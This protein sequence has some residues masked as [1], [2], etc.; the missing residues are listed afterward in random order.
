MA[1]SKY[2][3]PRLSRAEIITTLAQLQIANMVEQDFSNPNPDLISELYTHLLIHLDFLEEENEQLDFEAVSHFD[4]PELHMESIRAI[5]L[6]NRIK[7]VMAILECPRKF[8]LADLLTPDPQRTELFM[9]SILNFVLYRE[10]KLVDISN[11]G[12]EVSNLE[13]QR[14]KLEENEI[15]QVK[16]EISN[17]NE[18]REREMAVVQ[19]ADAKVAE[20]RNTIM[21]LNKNQMSLRTNL[22][23]LKDKVE[24]MD[25]KISNAEFTLSQNAQENEN[26]RSK[27]AQSPDKIQALPKL[28]ASMFLATN[29]WKAERLAMQT[30]HEK[31]AQLEVYSKV[32]K[33]MSKHYKQML[34]IKEQVNSAKSVEKELKALKA[35]LSDEEVLE[36]S[37]EAKL[38]ERQSKVVQMEE[39]KRQLEKECTVMREES[40]KYL[41]GITSDVEYKKRDIETRRI[42][43]EAVLSEV[44]A[45]NS[46]MKSVKESGAAKVELLGHKYE[47]IVNEF[48]KY[49]NSIAH[50]VE[51]GPKGDEFDI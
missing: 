28:I 31:T 35:K 24:E 14:M 5:K 7:E 1:A 41:N 10:G 4:N 39:M 17:L 43:V 26:L 49:A 20:L 12:D 33:K 47:E 8:T 25:S 16:S 46:K 32:G 34:A 19:E 38:V 42:N 50:V 48:R 13:E 3:Y 45:T 40:T 11:I 51:S 22:K 9:G 44:D 21:F 30:F 2:E 15:P 29:M 23:K 36:K 37:L 27:I 6:Y 18:A